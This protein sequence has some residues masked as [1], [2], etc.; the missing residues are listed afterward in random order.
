[1]ITFNFNLLLDEEKK[2]SF[3]NMIEELHP[4][5]LLRS[6]YYVRKRNEILV[7]VGKDQI[8]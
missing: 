6:T 2:T 5:I 4:T 7:V 3:P 1:M 8:C